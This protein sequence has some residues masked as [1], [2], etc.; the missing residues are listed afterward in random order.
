MCFCLICYKCGYS[1]FGSPI[2]GPRLF[3][4]S[5]S[6]IILDDSLG[7]STTVNQDNIH[8]KLSTLIGVSTERLFIKLGSH[9]KCQKSIKRMTIYWL[10]GLMA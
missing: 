1:N 9:K 4:L 10:N 7:H 2:F 5:N 3:T 8:P 6:F